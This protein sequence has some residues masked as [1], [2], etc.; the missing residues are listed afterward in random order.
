MTTY[1]VS[2]P[3]PYSLPLYL[4]RYSA[5]DGSHTLTVQLTLLVEVTHCNLEGLVGWHARHTEVGGGGNEGRD[6]F[7]V[8]EAPSDLL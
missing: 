1:L 7:S 5:V 6:C 2:G 4:P 8:L 3:V